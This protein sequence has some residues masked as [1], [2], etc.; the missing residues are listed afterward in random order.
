MVAPTSQGPFVSVVIPHRGG[1]KPLEK[2]IQAL[3]SQTYSRK[4]TEI[5]IVLNE[6]SQRSL[7][8]ALEPG[9]KL[10]WQR[11]SYSYAAR[12]LGIRHARGKIIALT[13]SDTLPSREWLDEAIVAI[14]SGFDLVAGSIEL[15]FSKKPLTAAACYEKL[16]AFDQEKNVRFGRATTANLAGRAD[17]FKDF[18]FAAGRATGEDFTWTRNTTRHGWSLGYA[19]RAVVLHPARESAGEIIVKAKRVTRGA[20]THLKGVNLRGAFTH[21]VS[22]YVIPPSK[23]KRKTSSLRE[24]T[25]GYTFSGFVIL[26][27]LWFFLAGPENTEAQGD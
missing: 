26:A 15:T 11:Q 16:F 21:F 23:S 17:I 24:K 22:L 3:R 2:C 8:F 14:D 25:L 12:N 4:N 9:E 6:E 19:S 13:D 20:F 18:P 27:K 10:L 7:S 1:D 5:L